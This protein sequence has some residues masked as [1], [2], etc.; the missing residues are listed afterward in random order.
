[1]TLNNP[2]VLNVALRYAIMVISA[3]KVDAYEHK[4]KEAETFA[5][6]WDD[7]LALLRGNNP[8]KDVLDVDDLIAEVERQ[9]RILE[10][11][12]A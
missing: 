10:E 1:M 7:L 2:D 11:L 3:Y 6:V 4:R 9:K 8:F 5:V 12:N